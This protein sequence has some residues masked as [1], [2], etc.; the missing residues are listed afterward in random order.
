LASRFFN[1]FYFFFNFLK[2][3]FNRCCPLAEP[4]QVAG[5]VDETTKRKR[6]NNDSFENL[7]TYMDF[8]C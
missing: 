1:F 7:K 8:F 2:F 4:L 5:V 3:F 6:G